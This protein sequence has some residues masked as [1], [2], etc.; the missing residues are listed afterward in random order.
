MFSVPRASALAVHPYYSAYLNSNKFD[1]PRPPKQVPY[2]PEM[3]PSMEQSL[4]LINE[5][6]SR[7]FPSYR[8]P[9]PSV[10][11]SKP[12][13]KNDIS[14]A[15]D[16]EEGE[17]ASFSDSENDGEMA[18]AMSD[19]MSLSVIDPLPL[20]RTGHGRP[21]L[22]PRT[23][24]ARLPLSE[25]LHHATPGDSF[26]LPPSL[27]FSSCVFTPEQKDSTIPP[28]IM[29]PPSKPEAR[30]YFVAP[31][32]AHAQELRCVNQAP[33][34][35]KPDIEVRTQSMAFASPDQDNKTERDNPWSSSLHLHL[36]HDLNLSPQTLHSKLARINPK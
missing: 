19:G 32:H 26:A 33:S 6:F 8:P 21:V 34:T 2:T 29:I 25:R 15:S 4:Q 1:K 31:R 14:Y 11:F 35:P 13:E 7:A 5:A 24:S 17:E 28:S 23:A 9:S 27:S 18:R 16:E 36:D 22:L 12:Q 30:K 3:T 10:S 20:E